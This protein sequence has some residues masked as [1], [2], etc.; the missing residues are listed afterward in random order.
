MLYQNELPY[1]PPSQADWTRPDGT[2]GWAGYKVADDVRRHRALRRRGLRLQPQRPLD[3]HRARLRGARPTSG[4]RLHHLL[5][6]NLEAGAIEHVVNDVGARVDS[7]A[8]GVPSYV[9]DYPAR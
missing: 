5:T 1:D 7:S 2:R 8:P 3:R 6:V 4:V 9:V